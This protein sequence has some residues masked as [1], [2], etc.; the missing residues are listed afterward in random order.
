MAVEPVLIGGKWQA[1]ANSGT[2]Q[3]ENPAECKLLPEVYPV[4]SWVDIDAALAAAAAIARE[5]RD[6]P[7][8]RIAIFLETYASLIE[9]R[10]AALVD[11][12]HGETALANK[13][14]LAE[15]E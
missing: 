3:A 13:P 4:S 9:E 11:M 15:V 14:R 8:E 7:G 2:F 10:A 1:S 6:T 12:A 5:L